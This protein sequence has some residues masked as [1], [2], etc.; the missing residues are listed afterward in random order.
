MEAK[1]LLEKIAEENGVSYEIAKEIIR[2][3]KERVYQKRRRT[4]GDMRALI[5]KEAAKDG[6]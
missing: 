4:R 6:E 2:I 1:E 5:E 3:E